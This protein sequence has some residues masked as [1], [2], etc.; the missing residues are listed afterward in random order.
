MKSQILWPFVPPYFISYASVHT[1]LQPPRTF[2]H[3]FHPPTAALGVCPSPG[4]HLLQ[5]AQPCVPPPIHYKNRRITGTAFIL[6]WR[7]A[8]ILVRYS[9]PSVTCLHVSPLS[10]CFCLTHRMTAFWANAFLQILKPHW[11]WLIV[12]R[13]S[14][15]HPAAQLSPFSQILKC[16]C[17]ITHCT[18]IQF[19]TANCSCFK[20]LEQDLISP[21]LWFRIY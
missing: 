2:H 5:L 11:I 19:L 16:L 17:C 3:I 14:L 6:L 18:K 1:G 13:N 9:K 8:K 21:G 4:G 10:T 7:K 20:N 12:F 15:P